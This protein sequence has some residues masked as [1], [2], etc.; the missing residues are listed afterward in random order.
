MGGS[1]IFRADRNLNTLLD[2]KYNRKFIADNGQK[3]GTSLKD[4]KNGEDVIVKVPIGTIVKDA[5][6]GEILLDMDEDG[7][8]E[9]FLKGGKGEKEILILQPPQIRLL[10]MRNQACQGKR[11]KLFSN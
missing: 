5:E 3:G 6:S 7:K 11:E 1:I 9:V 2:F 4:G 8:E 10:D